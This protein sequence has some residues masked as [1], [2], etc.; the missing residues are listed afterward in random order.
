[1]RLSI[2]NCKSLNDGHIQSIAE[3]WKY[4]KRLYVSGASVCEKVYD[5]FKN[6]P[7]VLGSINGRDIRGQD[8]LVNNL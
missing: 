7:D 8:I 1:M 2:C 4:L 6:R 3:Y 5:F